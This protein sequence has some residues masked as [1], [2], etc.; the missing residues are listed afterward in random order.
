VENYVAVARG[1]STEEYR[2]PGDNW[3]EGAKVRK[4]IIT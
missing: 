3:Q 2:K 1:K 4:S